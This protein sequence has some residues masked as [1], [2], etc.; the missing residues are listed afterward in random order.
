MTRGPQLGG[1]LEL[2]QELTQTI[3]AR[4]W[5]SGPR[6][7]GVELDTGAQSSDETMQSKMDHRMSMDVDMGRMAMDDPFGVQVREIVASTEPAERG[8]ATSEIAS[9]WSHG[10]RPRHR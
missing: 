10:R 6:A 2:G 4:G 5:R 3:R 1:L 8:R 7:P 9:G